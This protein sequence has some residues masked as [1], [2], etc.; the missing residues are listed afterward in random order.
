VRASKT[1]WK[2]SPSPQ[3]DVV[4]TLPDVLK[5]SFALVPRSDDSLGGEQ[6]I[7]RVLGRQFF[8]SDIEPAAMRNLILQ[9]FLQSLND[10]Q[11]YLDATLR[12]YDNFSSF[13]AAVGNE[14][15]SGDAAILYALTDVFV[16]TG[17]IIWYPGPSEP[18]IKIA[19]DSSTTSWYMLWCTGPYSFRYIEPTRP[20]NLARLPHFGV[21]RGPDA[22]INF[23]SDHPEA[24]MRE[25]TLY[26]PWIFQREIGG[27]LQEVLVSITRILDKD[28][29]II[30]TQEEEARIRATAIIARSTRQSDPA[31]IDI[32]TLNPGLAKLTEKN[33]RGPYYVKHYDDPDYSSRLLLTIM[34]YDQFVNS[35]CIGRR[36]E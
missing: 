13:I 30:Q 3:S 34:P 7:F 20:P 4:D 8:G 31:D 1:F 15:D 10:E 6:S 18:L 2:N 25:M 9:L 12:H 29:V 14:E 5:G 27:R 33:I 32:Q 16:D 35:W 23:S 28:H 36:E 11:R 22:L 17:F 19:K 21:I 26:I 24:P